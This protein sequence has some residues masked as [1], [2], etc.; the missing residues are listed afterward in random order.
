MGT[1]TCSSSLARRTDSLPSD[2]DEQHDR[3][4]LRERRDEK[5]HRRRDPLA[6]E[7][8]PK[9]GD[10]A[11]QQAAV[12]QSEARQNRTGRIASLRG[13]KPLPVQRQQPQGDPN[14]D[15][16]EP[17]DGPEMRMLTPKMYGAG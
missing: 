3:D 8:V 5:Q 15:I 17:A 4:R 14:D 9:F 16:D 6:A 11:R 12:E 1:S 13:W 2:R 7:H 10:D